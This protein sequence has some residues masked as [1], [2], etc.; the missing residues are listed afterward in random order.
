LLKN[1]G[2][3]SCHGPGSVHIEQ[4]REG[5]TIEAKLL[6][7]MNPYKTPPNETPAARSQ[8]LNRLDQSCQ[9]CHDNDNDVHWTKVPFLE[10][11]KL[12]EHNE[13]KQ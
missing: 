8:R 2:C 6:A 13:P 11:W 5:G 1:V 12:I 3:E 4:A 9:K 10:K 7:L